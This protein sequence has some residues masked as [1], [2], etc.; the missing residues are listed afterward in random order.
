MNKT[1]LLTAFLAFWVFA[2]S[3]FAADGTSYGPPGVSADS[4]LSGG[5]S[6]PTGLRGV[7]YPL[8]GKSI[9]CSSGGSHYAY[10]KVDSNG[11]M[12]IRARFYES[13]WHD[14]NYVRSNVVTVYSTADYS[15]KVTA[16]AQGISMT[17]A[18]GYL[19]QGICKCEA[20]W[21]QT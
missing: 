20:I 4:S 14:S 12:Y 7:F 9:S 18:C 1:G 10:A 3:V 2:A 19:G 15:I 13:G 5:A 8:R 16:Y 17:G 21:P 11:D 6:S